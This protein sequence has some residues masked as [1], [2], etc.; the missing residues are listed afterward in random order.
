MVY[1]RTA[2]GKV[3]IEMLVGTY[4]KYNPIE[5]MVAG[6]EMTMC[7]VQAFHEKRKFSKRLF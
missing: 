1:I 7:L 2:T 5:K 3:N 6:S 4:R